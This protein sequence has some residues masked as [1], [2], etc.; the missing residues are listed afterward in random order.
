M[1]PKEKTIDLI[2]EF[3]DVG[4]HHDFAVECAIIAVDEM[5][6]VLYNSNDTDEEYGYWTD[7]KTEILIIKKQI[8]WKK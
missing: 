1:T 8:K 2:K 6:K 7:V 4:I 3:Q 5:I